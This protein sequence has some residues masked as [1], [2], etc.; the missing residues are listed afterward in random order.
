MVVAV[1]T[2][3][4]RRVAYALEGDVGLHGVLANI[5]VTAGLIVGKQAARRPTD[6]KP[7]TTIQVANLR[8]T[9]RVTSRTRLSVRIPLA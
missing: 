2:L 5:K 4:R 9:S 7:L 6:A 3:A 1:V 8:V